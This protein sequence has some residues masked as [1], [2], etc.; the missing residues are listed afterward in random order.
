MEDWQSIV[1]EN[2]MKR[3]AKFM[4]DGDNDVELT[5]KYQYHLLLTSLIQNNKMLSIALSILE[6]F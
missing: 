1:K 6:M 3:I 4:F 5:D 2:E